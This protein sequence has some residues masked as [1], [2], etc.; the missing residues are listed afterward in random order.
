MSIG[1]PPARLRHYGAFLGTKISREMEAGLKAM[2]I[3]RGMP[4]ADLVRE[5]LAGALDSGRVNRTTSGMK[6][7]EVARDG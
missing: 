4:M 1:E 3:R 7:P 2:A 6:R 5:I